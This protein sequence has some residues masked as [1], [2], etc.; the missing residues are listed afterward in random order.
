MRFSKIAMIARQV[1][2]MSR[3]STL[4]P[5]STDCFIGRKE[6][7][8]QIVEKLI[9]KNKDIAFLE[10][11]LRNHFH[12]SSDPYLSYAMKRLGE[13]VEVSRLVFGPEHLEAKW[14]GEKNKEFVFAHNMREHIEKTVCEI[15]SN[16]LSNKVIANYLIEKGIMK[17]RPAFHCYEDS[18]PREE[19]LFVAC[20]ESREEGERFI[21][22][23]N[24][25]LK[26]LRRKC[27]Q[28]YDDL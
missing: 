20:F 4:S 8:D 28:I 23:I 1:I 9:V 15:L 22:Q 5:S 3:K 13:N 7:I 18:D 19:D 12:N 16:S 2:F 10:E 26:K 14:Q 21:N 27:E 11:T 17:E 6:A 24:Q 25:I